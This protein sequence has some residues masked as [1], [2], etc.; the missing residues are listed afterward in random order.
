MQISSP[1]LFAYFVS[2]TA[3]IPQST[4]ITKLTPLFFIT[5]SAD[6]LTPYPSISLSGK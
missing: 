5:S 2:S 4:V 3:V 1:I 6:V